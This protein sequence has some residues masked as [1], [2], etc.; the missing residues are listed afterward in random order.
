MGAE[1]R[2]R[3]PRRRPNPSAEE[4][5][6]A[7]PGG[8]SYESW[9]AMHDWRRREDR[10]SAEEAE[11][12]VRSLVGARVYDLGKASLSSD[13]DAVR[14]RGETRPKPRLRRTTR[15]V[16]PSR[17]RRRRALTYSGASTSSSR[18]WARRKHRG[19]GKRGAVE[20]GPTVAAAV[21]TVGEESTAAAGAASHPAPDSD[22]AAVASL[23]RRVADLESLLADRDVQLAQLEDERWRQD[24]QNA[25]L[26]LDVD[27]MRRDAEVRPVAAA[28]AAA[29]TRPNRRS[30][31][32]R[33]WTRATRRRGA[34]TRRTRL[35]CSRQ[36]DIMAAQLEVASLGWTRSRGTRSST[37]RTG[38]AGSTRGWNAMP[39]ASAR[40]GLAERLR[41]VE[42]DHARMVSE[43]AAATASYRELQKISDSFQAAALA[44]LER[45]ERLE[46]ELAEVRSAW[47]KE[48]ET[49]ASAS[50]RSDDAVANAGAQAEA[51]ARECE[52]M[53]SELGAARAARDAG[54]GRRR[55]RQGRSIPARAYPRRRR[56]VPRA[57]ARGGGRGTRGK[58]SV[59]DA[60]TGGDAR[61]ASPADEREGGGD[62][63][64]DEPAR[65]HLTRRSRRARVRAVE[66]T[67]RQGTGVRGAPRLLRKR[68]TRV[69]EGRLRRGGRSRRVSTNPSRALRGARTRGG[70]GGGA[71][72]RA[73]GTRLAV[74]PRRSTPREPRFPRCAPPSRRRKR[75]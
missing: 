74:E 73:R 2:R 9:R 1:R 25:K 41:E 24:E 28:D 70:R 34:R 40:R 46:I 61:R 47:E 60:G 17:R 22:A 49:A 26:D 57:R 15:R 51:S 52:A 48:R 67:G 42:R 68:R 38:P 64:G 20:L 59:F 23:A 5:P 7:A 32:A 10:R 72:S 21:A 62:H 43:A 13:G 69:R 63:R 56:G 58:D 37:S 31:N 45:R 50:R 18:R 11:E 35:R 39:S 54:D 53:R 19:R 66:T 3:F 29:R 36:A 71:R 55:R 16:A 65:I 75:R 6:V 27:A 12:E 33:L 8:G 44:E 30:G 4:T 14:A